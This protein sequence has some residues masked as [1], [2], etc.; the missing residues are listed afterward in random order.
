MGIVALA[1]SQEHYPI[2][3]FIFIYLSRQSPI[4]FY[5]H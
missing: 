5:Y 2:H 4:R 1:T 3:N